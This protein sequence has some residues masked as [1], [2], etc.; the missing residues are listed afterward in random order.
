MIFKTL[1]VGLLLAQFPFLGASGPALQASRQAPQAQVAAAD[2]SRA[3]EWRERRRRKLQKKAPETSS[4]LEKALVYVEDRGLREL[5]NIRYKDFYLKFGNLSPGSGLAPGIRYYKSGSGLSLES[6][7]AYSFAGYRLVDL[8]F[9]RFDKIAPHVFL[10]PADFGTPFKFGEERRPGQ[11]KSFLYTDLRYRHFPRERFYGIGPNSEEKRTDFLLEDVSY[12]AVAGYQFTHWLAVTVRFGYLQVNT[13]PGTD[14][15]FPD[16]HS[17]FTDSTAPGLARQPDFLHL[18]SAIYLD[19]RDTPGNAHQGGLVGISFSRFDDRGGRDFEFNRFSADVRHYLPLGS[20]QR[21]L[22]LRF[23]T[24]LDDADPGSRVP[25]YLQNTVG[26]NETLRGF[27]EFRFRD[28]RLIYLS[29]EYRWEAA[30]ALE[31][32]VF[33]DAGKVFPESED[34]D[35]K[36]LEKSIGAGVRF[37]TAKSVFLRLDVGRS[38][39]GTRIHFRFGPS[40]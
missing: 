31:F 23:F 25:F 29:A 35:F 38:D 16:T 17:L 30:P 4:G 28:S 1:F 3:E 34:F 10:G 9:G 32:A 14:D 33:Y 39:E 22:A 21:I 12:D 24:S 40:F 37:K 26:G 2:G 18:D 7:A 19:Y 5:L 36:H 20:K 11:V 15:R 8:Q 27:S 6:S 13:D